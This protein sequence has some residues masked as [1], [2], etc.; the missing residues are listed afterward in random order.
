MVQV[1]MAHARVSSG[2]RDVAGKRWFVNIG[3]FVCWLVL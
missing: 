1:G 3:L 2:C